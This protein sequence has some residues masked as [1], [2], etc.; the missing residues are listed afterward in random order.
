MRKKTERESAG[1]ALLVKPCLFQY[2]YSQLTHIGNGISDLNTGSVHSLN[3]I[4]CGTFAT[5]D[6]SAGMTHALGQR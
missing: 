4:G 2:L 1:V 6:D 3:L 5:C